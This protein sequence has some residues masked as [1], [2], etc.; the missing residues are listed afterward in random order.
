MKINK[1]ITVFSVL[2]TIIFTFSCKNNAQEYAIIQGKIQ[3][4]N[5]N[6]LSIKSGNGISEKEIAVLADGTFS[7]TIETSGHFELAIG[8]KG[9]KYGYKPHKVPL[10][11]DLGDHI[12]VN[13]SIEDKGIKAKF[14]GIGFEEAN[15]TWLK[16]SKLIELQKN[17]S[18]EPNA[19]ETEFID[20]TKKIKSE[21]EKLLANQQ[22]INN[23][24][25]EKEK[26]NL[27]Y[28]YLSELK[29]Y[30]SNVKMSS[31]DGEGEVSNDVLAEFDTFSYD[32]EADY[33]FSQPYRDI[34]R[35][36]YSMELFDF[37]K[38]EQTSFDEGGFVVAK[39]I[40]N[41]R[42][43]NDFLFYIVS[44]FLP[45]SVDKTKTYDSFMMAST[46]Y[47]HKTKITALYNKFLPKGMTS[48]KFIDYE[49]AAGGVSSLDDFK[50]KYVYIDVWAT[51]CGPCIKEFPYIKELEHQLEGKNVQFVGISI[52][53]NDK[54]KEW[55]QMII[56]K[57]LTSVQLLA[58]NAWKS[59]FIEA[60]NIKSIP[61]FILIDP[62][63]KIINSK[64]PRPSSDELRKLFEANRIIIE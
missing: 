11:I 7:D 53:E 22:G 17:N 21:I 9:I 49:N 2:C 37:V 27:N 35:H 20:R 63:G 24:F 42:M 33:M 48:P 5:E 16:K 3:N 60:Y 36:H 62:E 57:G 47:E 34:I 13:L 59:E 58:D 15:Y 41:P 52:D 40:E 51:W 46:N 1:T 54:K 32:N 4:L 61:Y 12:N 31:P 50:G 38:K 6:V 55:K 25:I 64:S 18:L 43:K 44:T 10:Y 30:I 26:R 56:D 19:N 28:Y 8:R 29:S 39:N 45:Q 23:D 14:S